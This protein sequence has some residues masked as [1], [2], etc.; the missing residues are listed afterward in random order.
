MQIAMQWKQITIKL[1]LGTYLCELWS[2]Y[3]LLINCV[4]RKSLINYWY[5]T[6]DFLVP[7]CSISR[8]FITYLVISYFYFCVFGSWCNQ[9]KLIFTCF[10][11]E[12]AHFLHLWKDDDYHYYDCDWNLLMLGT[13]LHELLSFYC[14]LINDLKA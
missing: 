1:I 7:T 8:A 2:F 5:D 4:A 14:L 10:V 9:S 13:Y 6:L 3:C 12:D 11:H